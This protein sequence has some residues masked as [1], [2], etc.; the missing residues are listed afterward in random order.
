MNELFPINET[1]RTF[2]PETVKIFNFVTVSRTLEKNE[3]KDFCFFGAI[4]P[5]GQAKKK[6]QKVESVRL[7]VQCWIQT[8]NLQLPTLNPIL[9]R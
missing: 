5:R 7:K 2:T 3:I 9:L 4:S 6:M 1:C 8:F